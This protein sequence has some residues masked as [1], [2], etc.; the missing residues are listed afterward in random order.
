MAKHI[1]LGF[2]II[3]GLASFFF[4]S[5]KAVTMAKQTHLGF[6]IKG[7]TNFFRSAKAVTMA[8]QIIQGAGWRVLPTQKKRKKEMNGER[9]KDIK[10]ER[11][12]GRK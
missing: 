12:K 5:L 11:K 8:K 3:K 10:T 1:H 2:R 7:F 6:R 4:R 9:R